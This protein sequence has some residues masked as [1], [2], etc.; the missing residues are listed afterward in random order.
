MSATETNTFA[1]EQKLR[2]TREYSNYVDGKWVKSV[3]GKTFENRN[4]ADSE[5]LKNIRR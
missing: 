2:E 5:D 4:P 3:S 1:R